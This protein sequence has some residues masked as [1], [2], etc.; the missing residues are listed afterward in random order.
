MKMSSLQTTQC[1]LLIN[2]VVAPV[3]GIWIWVKSGFFSAVLFVITWLIA[4]KVWDWL[5][6]LLIAG[7]GRIRANEHEA[8]QMEISGEV[9]G[10]MASMMI[11]DLLGTFILPW[12]IA[13][14]FLGWFGTTTSLST[15][16]AK[17]WWIAEYPALIQAVETADNRTLLT[18]YRTGPSGDVEV[19]LTLFRKSSGGLILK[20][21]LPPQAILSIAPKMGEKIPN[22]TRSL[23]TIRDR[24][25]DGMPNDF[26]VEPSG[27]PLNKEAVRALWSIAIGFSINHFLHGID[28]ALPRK[29]EGF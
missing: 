27:E 2:W 24:N 20:L 4:D 25:E 13:G 16:P 5:T 7:A 28:S 22:S 9:P 23:I 6:G 3:L 21:N 14:F 10:R 11:V 12:V 15:A 17:E 19:K 18:N 26:N 8:F 1:I 29:A